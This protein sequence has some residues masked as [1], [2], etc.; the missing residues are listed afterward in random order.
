[1]VCSFCQLSGFISIKGKP[2]TNLLIVG[3]SVIILT[4]AACEAQHEE[5]HI[6]EIKIEFQR[7]E[8]S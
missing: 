5:E 6:D 3:K 8:D 2:Q 4:A 1:M 7:A